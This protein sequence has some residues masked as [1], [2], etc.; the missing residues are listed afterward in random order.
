V[1]NELHRIYL[2]GGEL[3]RELWRCFPQP[4]SSSDT[5]D[6]AAKAEKFYEALLRF[7]NVK[8]RPFEV[9]LLRRYSQTQRW[10]ILN[11]FPLFTKRDLKSWF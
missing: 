5:E 6:N 7:R 11:L 9:R 8:L 1:K 10:E 4:G 3:L 2:S